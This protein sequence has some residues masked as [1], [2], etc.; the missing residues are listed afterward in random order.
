MYAQLLLFLFS[1]SEIWWLHEAAML[2][3]INFKLV[4]EIFGVRQRGRVHL[5]QVIRG[6]QTFPLVE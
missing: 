2:F 5:R 3:E 4:L 6:R 1:S